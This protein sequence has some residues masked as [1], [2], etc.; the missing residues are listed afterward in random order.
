MPIYMTQFA[1]TKEAAAALVK[2]PEDRSAV[3]REQ[4]E[5]LGGRVL[6]FYHCVGEYDGLTIYEVPDEATLSGL[7]FA[8]RASGH[9]EKIETTE[10]HTVEVA[11]KGMRTA[12]KQSYQV[13]RDWAAEHDTELWSGR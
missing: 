8:I 3:F 5:K 7:V 4:V 1:Y 9:L 11:M 10:L 2:N 6:A 13:P 12:S